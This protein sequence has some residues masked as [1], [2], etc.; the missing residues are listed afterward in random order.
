MGYKNAEAAREYNQAY[1]REHKEQHLENGR[2]WR[3]NNID[4]A[5]AMARESQR[6]FLASQ[7]EK[8]KECRRRN[9]FR[10]KYGL[11]VA[12]WEAMALL[13]GGKCSLCNETPEKLHVDHCHRSGKVR[14]L[15]CR[16]CNVALGHL[17]ENP[18]LFRKAAEYLERHQ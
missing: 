6:R 2:R 18:E 13:Q 16:L 17:K 11:T 15:L 1:Y 12:E 4:K 14:S 3:A 5:R 10:R 8:A 9:Q 7:P